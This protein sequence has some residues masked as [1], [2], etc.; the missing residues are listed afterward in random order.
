M[1]SKNALHC[2]NLRAATGRVRD[3]ADNLKASTATKFHYRLRCRHCNQRALAL[4]RPTRTRHEIR[5][6]IPDATSS[7]TVNLPHERR[8]HTSRNK[9]RMGFPKSGVELEDSR[10][11]I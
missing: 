2:V 8:V 7:D 3:L 9:F 5:G 10:H 11:R 4:I 6:A 1:H